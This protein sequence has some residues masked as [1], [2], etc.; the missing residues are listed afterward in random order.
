MHS[1]RG[2]IG[3]LITTLVL[4]ICILVAWESN[5]DAEYNIYPDTSANDNW[6]R[7]MM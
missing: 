1:L 5:D 7:P 2:A 6:Y 4:N 3:L